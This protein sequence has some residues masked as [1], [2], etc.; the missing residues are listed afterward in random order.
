MKRIVKISARVVFHKT[1]SIEI[2][3]PEYVNISHVG[4]WLDDTLDMGTMGNLD[5][6]LTAAPLVN[7]FGLGNGFDDK[8]SDQEFRYDIYLGDNPSPITGGHLYHPL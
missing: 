7:S 4:A 2:E 1:A 5:D 6:E 8:E 3:I